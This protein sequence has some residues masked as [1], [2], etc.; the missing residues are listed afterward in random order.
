MREFSYDGPTLPHDDFFPTL[1]KDQNLINVATHIKRRKDGGEEGG[2][3]KVSA[4]FSSAKPAQ[5]KI[6]TFQ[7]VKPSS[8]IKSSK[9][10]NLKMNSTNL[11]RSYSVSDSDD[12][13]E[14]DGQGGGHCAVTSGSQIYRSPTRK[15][16]RGVI[17]KRRRDRIN[18]SL[19]ELKRLVPQALEK[20]GSA[21]L[22][23]AEILQM[24]V[25]HLKVLHSNKVYD[26]NGSYKGAAQADTHKIATDYHGL[27]RSNDFHS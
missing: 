4:N 3:F 2:F 10:R 17:E 14:E 15:R 19:D 21:K 25:D 12:C 16:R 24:T 22:E 27:G 26:M 20:S 1:N 6:R 18:C 8:H 5:G 7:N 23:K 11:K 9:N 13:S